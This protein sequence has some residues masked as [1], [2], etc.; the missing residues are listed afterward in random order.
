MSV[1]NTAVLLMR[2]P[3]LSTGKTSFEGTKGL[4]TEGPSLH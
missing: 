1:I 2:I 4:G 3:V